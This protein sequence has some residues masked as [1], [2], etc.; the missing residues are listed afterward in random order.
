MK[1]RDLINVIDTK[2]SIVNDDQ[3][4]NSDSTIPEELMNRAVKSIKS[5][6]N[7][8]KIFLKEPMRSNSLEDLGYS[9]ETGI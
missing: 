3:N 1:V 4:Y 9:F 8:I 7:G 2:F 6:E 5:D